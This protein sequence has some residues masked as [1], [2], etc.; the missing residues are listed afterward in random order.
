M[1]SKEHY[2][3]LGHNIY[4]S[5]PESKP[6]CVWTTN[7]INGQSWTNP[8]LANKVHNKEAKETKAYNSRN[9]GTRFEPRTQDER[10]IP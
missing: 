1:L 6:V 9:T 7:A 2:L 10:P 4:S 3:R 8:Y 5:S